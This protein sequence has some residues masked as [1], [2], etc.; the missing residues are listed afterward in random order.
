MELDKSM[1][2]TLIIQKEKFCLKIEEQ[3][4]ALLSRLFSK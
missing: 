1:M 4:G 2:D 3:L